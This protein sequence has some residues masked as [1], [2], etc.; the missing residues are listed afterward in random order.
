MLPGKLALPRVRL[1]AISWQEL[2]APRVRG[3]VESSPGSKLPL[4]LGGQRLA[5]PLSKRF[6]IAERDMYNRMVIE[7]VD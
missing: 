4:G 3:P 2:V 6:R 1:V 5:F 7:P